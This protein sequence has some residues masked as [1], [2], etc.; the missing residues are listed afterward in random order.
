MVKKYKINYKSIGGTSSTSFTLN[1]NNDD[2]LVDGLTL[3]F[4]WISCNYTPLSRTKCIYCYR[5]H[6][7]SNSNKIIEIF[8]QIFE[9]WKEL[10]NVF[11]NLWY[12]SDYDE[13]NI[14]KLLIDHRVKIFDLKFYGYKLDE[15]NSYSYLD[16]SDNIQY[17]NPLSDKMNYLDKEFMMD[18]ENSEKESTKFFNNL[19][20]SHTFASSKNDDYNFTVSQTIDSSKNNDYYLTPFYLKI[21]YSKHVIMAAQYNKTVCKTRY[22][23]FLD[24]DVPTR[25]ILKYDLKKYLEN[26]ENIK[27]DNIEA[28]EKLDFFGIILGKP[29]AELNNF[30]NSFIMID[31]TKLIVYDA[32]KYSNE[33]LEKL[34]K[35]EDFK[36]IKLS[37]DKQQA[38]YQKYSFFFQY[39][40]L[41][42]INDEKKLNLNIEDYKYQIEIRPKVNESEYDYFKINQNMKSLLDNLETKNPEGMILEKNNLEKNNPDEMIL[43]KN[44]LEILLQEKINEMNFLGFKYSILDLIEYIYYDILDDDENYYY[45][46]TELLLSYLYFEKKE[47]FKKDK[48]TYFKGEFKYNDYIKHI[49][50]NLD[51]YSEIFYNSINNNEN[52][53][54]ILIEDLCFKE[55][56]PNFM[57]YNKNNVLIRP[58]IIDVNSPPSK[59][60]I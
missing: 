22:S 8:N 34:V 50:E 38:V 44:N 19:E 41:C 23:C 59:F 58:F 33:L 17:E 24:I 40:L 12:H 42:F 28:F 4:L 60:E 7:N 5:Y 56:E 2:S 13:V 11:I 37:D 31:T 30:E 10:N 14:Q 6:D 54:S 27:Y 49:F 46:K 55:Y 3:N 43:E 53:R 15:I 51:Y 48:Q 21:D 32:L 25:D 20:N 9:Q 52:L 47:E 18:L 45:Q 35:M 39:L 57:K 36:K 16:D 29:Y 1:T 26:D